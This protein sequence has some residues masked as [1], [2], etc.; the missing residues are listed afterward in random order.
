MISQF[1][2]PLFPMGRLTEFVKKHKKDGLKVEDLDKIF[3]SQLDS[4]AYLWHSL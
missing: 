4:L 3:R 1:G 2:L